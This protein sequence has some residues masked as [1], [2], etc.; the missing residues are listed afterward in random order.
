VLQKPKG[1]MCLSQMFYSAATWQ[2]I[3]S[4]TCCN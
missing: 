2:K 3:H 4:D 1:S